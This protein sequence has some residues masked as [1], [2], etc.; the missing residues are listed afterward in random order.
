MPGARAGESPGPKR[1]ILHGKRCCRTGWQVAA[2]TSG[3]WANGKGWPCRGCRSRTRSHCCGARRQKL[4]VRTPGPKKK[5][6]ATFLDIAHALH[7][8]WLRGI[9][10]HRRQHVETAAPPLAGAWIS[11]C[12]RH[13]KPPGAVFKG[14]A[15]WSCTAGVQGTQPARCG[16]SRVVG[17]TTV[18]DGIDQIRFACIVTGLP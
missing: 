8:R 10:S 5:A 9:V 6:C 11:T 4:V 15:A 1:L 2:A 17:S 3:K 13:A 16:R 18:G 14:F 7:P 12:M